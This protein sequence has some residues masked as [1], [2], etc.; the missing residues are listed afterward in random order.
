MQRLNQR[1]AQR[2]ISTCLALAMCGVN[3]ASADEAQPPAAPVAEQ[4]P[5]GL[6]LVSVTAWPSRIQLQNPWDVTQ[7]LITGQ[8]DTGE[9]IDLT[10]LAKLAMPSTVVQVNDTGQVRPTA[11]GR[12]VLRFEVA[13]HAVEI[14]I[15]VDAFQGAATDELRPRRHAGFVED[16]L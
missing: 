1:V 2:L 14:P 13:E 11:D 3:A 7:I 9:Q 12:D 4:I 15:E 5:A 16:G 10:R 6:Q 8:L